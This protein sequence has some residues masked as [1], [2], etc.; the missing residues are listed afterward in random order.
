MTMYQPSLLS[1]DSSTSLPLDFPVKISAGTDIKKALWK[2]PDRAYSSRS[3]DSFASADPDTSYWRTSQL[4][5][6]AT[7]GETWEQYSGSFPRSGTMRSGKLYRQTHWEPPTSE[8]GSGLLPTPLASDMKSQN[9]KNI[10]IN[11]NGGFYRQ[12]MNGQSC[13]HVT[14]VMNYLQRP[15]LA[16]SPGFREEMMG[17]PEGWT[18]VNG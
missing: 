18:C 5:L 7:E 8:K 16:T 2:A 1:L 17:Y 12:E 4:C 3:S 13:A 9:G 11:K 15:D 14:N 6:L 10:K